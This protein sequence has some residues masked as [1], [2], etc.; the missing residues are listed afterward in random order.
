MNNDDPWKRM[1]LAHGLMVQPVVPPGPMAGG[2]L[3]PLTQGT[4]TQAMGLLG[5]G[6]K[7]NDH[8]TQTWHDGPIQQSLTAQSERRAI[9]TQRLV[10]A[11]IRGTPAHK[12]KADALR[13]AMGDPR[14][15]PMARMMIEGF[16]GPG[17]MG[18]TKAVGPVTKSLD[19]IA[20]MLSGWN[21]GAAAVRRAGRN[22]YGLNEAD[23]VRLWPMVEAKRTAKAEAWRALQESPE[24]KAGVAARQ[25]EARAASAAREAEANNR[26]AARMQQWGQ[27]AKI[28]RSDRRA[29]V[30]EL[31]RSGQ[32]RA[33]EQAAKSA[34]LEALARLSKSAGV[35]ADHV[36][37][38]RAGT[39]SSRYF[40]MSKIHPQAGRVRVSDH[41]LPETPQRMFMREQGMGGNWK[42]EVVIEPEML[43]RSPDWWRRA[44]L[45]AATGKKS[46]P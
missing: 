4:V 45:L 44:L 8:L 12:A 5:L 23:A 24:Y 20:E 39:A 36:S 22:Q 18:V 42:G 25:A 2:L 13:R 30:E 19:E 35:P 10:E 40:D 9:E 41:P 7:A 32:E 34:T 28:W 27:T 6:K 16:T 38:S 43:E 14:D 29:H 1:F 26:V 46:F 11:L 15:D 37:K 17:V 33:A 31:L 21:G 3:G